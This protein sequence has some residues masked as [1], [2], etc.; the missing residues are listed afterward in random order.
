MHYTAF[1]AIT[2]QQL[3]TQGIPFIINQNAVKTEALR[4]PRKQEMFMNT[5]ISEKA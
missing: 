4:N 3:E 2:K 5:D 1:Q